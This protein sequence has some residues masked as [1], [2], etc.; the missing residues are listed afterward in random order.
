MNQINTIEDAWHLV[1]ERTGGQATCELKSLSA[2]RKMPYELGFTG[3]IQD[4]I[5]QG[6]GKYG[7]Q[8]G[9][10]LLFWVSSSMPKEYFLQVYPW[11]YKDIIAKIFGAQ[12]IEVGDEVFD[13]YFIIKSNNEAL[14]RIFLDEE[15]RRTLLQTQRG[16]FRVENGLISFEGGFSLS[17]DIPERVWRMIGALVAMGKR[18]FR[19]L[20]QWRE[21][22]KPLGGSVV[23]QGRLTLD[24]ET[25]IEAEVRGVNLRIELSQRK[26]FFSQPAL[27]TQ[28]KG[29]RASLKG[30]LFAV[31]KERPKRAEGLRVV[32][33][34]EPLAP[35][36]SRGYQIYAQDEA[37]L[38]EAFDPALLERLVALSF[39]SLTGEEG[40]VT[41]CLS[42]LEANAERLLLAASVVS[43]LCQAEQTSPY[44]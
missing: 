34:S 19:W 23:S 26:S 33:A 39:E 24:G 5:V 43:A 14:T 11:E 30:G 3:T 1:G 36:M 28:L 9:G 29:P 18:G 38:L 41:L 2:L 8:E 12:D 35:L 7:A 22:A 25:R 42:G 31:A 44:R 4:T 21:A 32:S 13:R 6:E 27:Y 16:G 37:A 15:V 20:A 17:D 40:A 10:T